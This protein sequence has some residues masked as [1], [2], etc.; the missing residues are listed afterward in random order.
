MNMRT[1]PTFLGIV[2][3]AGTLWAQGVITGRVA[4]IKGEPVPGA[5][6]FLDGTYDGTTTLADGSFEFATEESGKQTL[7]VRFIGYKEFKKE[8]DLDLKSITVEAVLTEALNQ[9]EAVTITAGSFQASDESRRTIFKAMDIATTAGATADIAGALNTLP[10]TQKV[11][12]SGRLFVRGGDGNEARTF[13]DG[14]VVMN[15]YNVSS[16]KAP[17]RGRFLPFMFKGTS[18]STGGYSAEYGQALSSTLVLD[19]K[20]KPE[21]TCTDFGILSVGADVTHTQV[22]ERSSLAGKIQ[23]TDIRPYFDLINQEVDWITPPSSIESNTVFRHEIGKNGMLKAYGN[24]NHTSFSLYQHDIDDPSV[25]WQYDLTNDYG[26]FN[27]TYRTIISENWSVRSGLSY[28]NMKNDVV[29]D[30]DPV[31]EAERGAHVKTVVEGSVSD[32]IELRTGTEVIGRNY[33]VDVRNN[34]KAFDEVIGSWFAESDLYAS[35]NFV[36]RAGARV[37]YNSL[38]DQLSVDPRF[39]LACKLGGNGNLSLAYGKFRQSPGNELLRADNSLKSEKADHYIASYQVIDSKRT[40]RAEVFH[41]RYYDLVKYANI[42]GTLLNNNGNGYA[43]GVEFFW[44]D[45]STFKNTDYWI[46]YSFTD[47]ER[48]YLNFPYMATPVFVSRHNFSFV[49][50][51]FFPRL[52]TQFGITY[53]FA[54]GRPYNDPNKEAFNAGRTPSYHDVSLNIAYLPRA[55]VILYFS[56]TNLPGRDNIFGYEFSSQPNGDVYNRRPIRQ[57]ARRFLLAG[58]FI[59]LSRDKSKNQ[60][61]SL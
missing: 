46:S 37:E 15:A 59:T 3:G 61:P 36:T 55:N 35:N 31:F 23:Y 28:T 12:E 7:V 24:F 53:S 27:T 4:D 48:D 13:I 2:L 11:G 21:M 19:S 45:N 44:R 39:S 8:V 1:L 49:Y 22:W 42:E 25:K 54:S 5:N 41:K 20:D 47:S 60:L 29:T 56:A 14:M 6:V 34:I 16:P 18:F 32:H 30:G 33:S 43:R 10:G 9:L 58:I 40:F 26:Y 38:L 50:K 17:S 52:K 57:A 51:H